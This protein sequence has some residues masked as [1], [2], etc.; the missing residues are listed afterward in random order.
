MPPD[1]CP[2]CGAEIPPRAKAC[3]ECGSC[4]QTGWSDRAHADRLGIP[5]ESFD[6]DR[7]VEEEFGTRKRSKRRG[8]WLWVAVALGLLALALVGYLL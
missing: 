4:E 3:P 5:D 8:Q 6:Y 1:Y 7:F 2:Q